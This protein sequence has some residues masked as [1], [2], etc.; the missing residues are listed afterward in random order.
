MS[1][2][3]KEQVE[4]IR[5]QSMDAI[6][7]AALDLFAHKGYASTSISA[8]AKAAG[9]SKGLMYN[10]YESKEKLLEAIVADAVA[11]GADVFTKVMDESL[12]PKERLRILIE[13]AFDWVLS[14]FVYYKLIVQ[15]SFQ[16]DVIEQIGD[17]AKQK[18][19]AHA[20]FGELLFREL[21]YEHPRLEA[22][23]LG[24][25]LDGVFMQLIYLE[26]DY[27]IHEMKEFILKKYC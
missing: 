12:T 19:E 24:A 14:H 21:G 3:T 7:Q 20:Q 25:T 2:K 8:I 1:P 5:Q 26:D 13:W 11:V 9:V 16:E 6:K 23:Q 27:P 17:F 22:L 10:Y 4:V 18:A 15:L